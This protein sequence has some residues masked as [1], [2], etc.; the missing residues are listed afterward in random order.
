M[1]VFQNIKSAAVLHARHSAV[2]LR[3]TARLLC[4]FDNRVASNTPCS[5]KREGSIAI[6]ICALVSSVFH[7]PMTQRWAFALFL[8]IIATGYVHPGYATTRVQVLGTFPSGNTVTLSRNKLFYL[9]LH[10]DTNH[11]IGIWV[12][13]YFKGK[14]VNAGTSPSQTYNGSGEAL[15][16]FELFYPNTHVDE[17]RITA[18]DGSLGGTPVVATFPVQISSSAQS[19]GTHSKPAW[20]TRLVA[21]DAAAEKADY[22]RHMNAPISSRDVILFNGFVL[23]MFAVG[24]LGFA[25]PAW[26]MWHWRGGWRLAAIVPAAMM[27]FVVL[28]LLFDTSRDPTS[29]NLWP[30]E[31]LQ[32]GVLSTVIMLVF[33]VARKVTGVSRA[34]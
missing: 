16:W 10:Y 19:A 14:A 5:Y 25:A 3:I 26:G 32:V 22:E 31:I 27:T 8:A 12:Q 11:P 6:W 24:V 21:R 4:P 17:V 9:H 30:F 15:G 28:R 13:P 20:V 7:H 1:L 2:G 18:G 29:H 23:G 33:V 34:L